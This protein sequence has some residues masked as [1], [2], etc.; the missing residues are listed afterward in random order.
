MCHLRAL[1]R[2]GLIERDPG[3]ARGIRCW[4]STTTDFGRPRWGHV[5]RPV[6]GLYPR[7]LAEGLRTMSSRRYAVCIVEKGNIL[8][9]PA[10]ICL[11]AKL[12]PMPGLTTGRRR[13]GSPGG[14]SPDFP[15]NLDGKIQIALFVDL[16]GA[17]Q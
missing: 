13:P 6:R 4:R 12:A 9:A 3:T 5:S 10:A 14:A 11:C 7:A 17:H 15:S 16:G 8:S 2:L 1:E